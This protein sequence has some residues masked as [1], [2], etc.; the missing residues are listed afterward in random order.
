MGTSYAQGE[1]AAPRRI[2]V[3]R[4]VLTAC[5][6][7][8][9]QRQPEAGVGFYSRARFEVCGVQQLSADDRLGFCGGKLRRTRERTTDIA[10]RQ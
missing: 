8:A 5:L 2:H 1:P 6:A 9:S 3:R 10:R 4:I 7:A